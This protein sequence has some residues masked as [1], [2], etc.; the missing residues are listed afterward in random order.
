MKNDARARYTIMRIK[1]AFLSL[2]EKKPDSKITVREICELAEINRA[3]FY[4]HYQDIY[5]LKEQIQEETVA[6]FATFVKEQLSRSRSIEETLCMILEGIDGCAQD[7]PAFIYF[8]RDEGF[9]KKFMGYFMEEFA[10]EIR[11]YYPQ[12]SEEER[13]IL[14]QFAS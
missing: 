8:S 13:R 9:L 7:D 12:Y 5:A 14:Y 6:E 3:T 4:H 1:G 2:A 10:E 11:R